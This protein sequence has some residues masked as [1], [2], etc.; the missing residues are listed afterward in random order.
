VPVPKHFL[1]R[2]V[3][4]PRFGLHVKSGVMALEMPCRHCSGTTA[5][6]PENPFR[7][8]EAL[9][10]DG[11]SGLFVASCWHCEGNALHYW[12]D[13]YDDC[14]HYWCSIA[15]SECQALRAAAAAGEDDTG[16]SLAGPKAR[17]F[18][19]QRLVLCGHPVH[20]LGW[21]EGANSLLEGAPW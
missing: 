9:T 3:P 2:D 11:H 8:L 10:D 14:W 1:P 5:G 18:L 21:S 7:D 16:E 4:K 15:E 13:I 17:E 20:G 19:R 6:R 12:V